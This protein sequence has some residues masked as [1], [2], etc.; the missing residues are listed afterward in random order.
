MGYQNFSS[1]AEGKFELSWD[2][3]RMPGDRNGSGYLIIRDEEK[4][5]T[6]AMEINVETTTIDVKLEPGVIITGKAVDPNNHA[7]EGAEILV[8]LYAL[9]IGAPIGRDSAKTN[10]EGNFEIKAIPTEQRYHIYGRAEGYGVKNMEIDI[11]KAVDN[12][13]DVGTIKLPVANLTVSGVV[14]DVNDQ[15]VPNVRIFSYGDNQPNQNTQTD[16]EGRFEVK[17]CEGRIRIN[18]NSPGS[19]RLYGRIETEGGSSDVKI[20]ISERQTSTAYIPKQPPSLVGKSLP[21]L[22]GLGIEL[23]PDDTTDKMTLVCF[24]DMQQRPSRHC[25]QQLSKKAQQLKEKNITVVAVH[26]KAEEKTLNEWITENN[27]PFSVGLIEDDEEKIRYNW[28]VRSL[29]WMILTD[30][31]RVVTAEGFGIDELDEEIKTLR[32]K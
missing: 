17:V 14:V 15:P 22:K 13:L 6:V 25:L 10:A 21:D 12:H 8:Y 1:D 29:P 2:P 3:E 31:N 23:Q 16:A 4:N 20:V 26:T 27:I 28:G 7:I 19:T 9:S 30:E 18:A 11:Y 24:F 32:E 5:L